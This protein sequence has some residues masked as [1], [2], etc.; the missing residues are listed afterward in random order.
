MNDL[1]PLTATP[2][3]SDAARLT[4]RFWGV[5]GSI[6]TPQE[7][8]LG[9]G[10]NT[11]C[12]EVRASDGTTLV[13]DA[14]TGVRSLGYSLAAEAAGAP[15]EVHLILS[16]F[17]WDH[18][19][20]LPFFAPLYTP[21]QNVRFYAATDDDRLLGLLR[22]Q[23]C[24]PYFPVPFG[25]VAA[26]TETIRVEDGVPFTVGS[27]TIQ[28]FPVFHPQGAHG[29]RI[30][31]DGAVLV[32]ATDYEH[33]SERHDDGLREVARGADLL[34]SDAQY[35]PDEYVLRRGWGH[36]T[37]EHATDLAAEAG[38]GRLLLFHH[39]PAHDDAALA[40]ICDQARAR[41]PATDLAM[42]GMEIRL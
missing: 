1:P 24:P 13:L 19:Q 22:G 18:L 34:I 2:G 14:G 21:G 40:R 41:F 8:F 16:H 17:H 30:E 3:M 28:P 23:M 37:W 27:M 38:V 25:D 6:P 36:T 7:G 32:Y 4:I 39:D 31:V 10:G 20:G 29:F 15:T 42:E 9:V 33:G 26:A 5:R 11:S 35:T 12:V